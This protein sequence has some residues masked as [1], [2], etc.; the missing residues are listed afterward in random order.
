MLGG[1]WAL[2]RDGRYAAAAFVLLA[3]T[4]AGAALALL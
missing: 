3:V 1:R 2:L 4:G